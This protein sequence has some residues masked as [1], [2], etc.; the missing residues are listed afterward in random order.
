MLKWQ[1]YQELLQLA[2]LLVDQEIKNKYYKIYNNAII[3][4][5]L[6]R[7]FIPKTVLMKSN[8]IIY[9][10]WQITQIKLHSH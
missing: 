7:I 9:R 2:C 1:N 5:F 4:L 3:M 10:V 8:L 6:M